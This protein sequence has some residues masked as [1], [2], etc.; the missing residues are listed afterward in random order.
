METEKTNKILEKLVNLHFK[1]AKVWGGTHV[2]LQVLLYL[3]G[4]VAVFVPSVT[5]SYPP[6]ALVLALIGAWLSG[7]ASKFKGVADSLK[8]QH[9][10]WQGLGPSPPTGLLADMRVNITGDLSE[11][12]N[13]LLREGLTFSSSK[14]VGPA[15]VLEN[16]S[17]STWFTKHLAGWCATALCTVF[18]LTLTGAVILLLVSAASLGDLTVR[19]AAAKCVAATFTFLLSI[20]VVRSWLAFSRYSQKAGEI[21]AEAQRLLKTGNAD[22][23]TAQRVLGE[24]QLLR[25]SAP[26]IPTW[27]WEWQ[28]NKLNDNWRELKCATE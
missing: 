16:L 18:V 23:L 25:A 9:E 3:A 19:V 7:Q 13:R 8:R 12:E 20:G 28:R 17:E 1:K 14:A 2:L 26:L 11:E 4:V 21:E 22:T 15:R 24:Y 10:Y 5:T 6:V 27:V